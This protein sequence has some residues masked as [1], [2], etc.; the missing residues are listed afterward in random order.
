MRQNPHVRICGGPRSATTLVY[1]TLVQMLRD[2][3]TQ[4]PDWPVARAGLTT[5]SRTE[6]YNTRTSVQGAPEH[7]GFRLGR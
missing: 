1:P 3:I 2:P 7:H 6:G 4:L 5:S